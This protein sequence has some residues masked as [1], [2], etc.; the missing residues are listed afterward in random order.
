MRNGVI[1]LVSAGLSFGLG[2]GLSGA[3]PDMVGG[4]LGGTATPITTDTLDY[5]NRLAQELAEAVEAPD[6]TRQLWTEGT[7]L[8]REGHIRGGILRLRRAMVM[9]HAGK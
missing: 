9:V 8:C 4:P 6:A 3:L 7:R 5:C 2:I 1:L